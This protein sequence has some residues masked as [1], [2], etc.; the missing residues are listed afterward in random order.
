MAALCERE[1]NVVVESTL[2]GVSLAQQIQLFAEAGY[3]ISLTYVFLASPEMSVNRVAG[4]VLEGGHYV[5]SAD[6]LRRVGRSKKN[7]WHTYRLL[8]DEWQLVYNADT[9]FIYV[10]KFV[11]RNLTVFNHPVFR[12]FLQEQGINL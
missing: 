2:S 11:Q 8:A 5:P 12:L 10:A 7:F 1:A 4:R 6:I 9:G 3:Y